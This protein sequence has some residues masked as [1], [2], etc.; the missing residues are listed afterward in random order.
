M[1]SAHIPRA[2][3]A[4]VPRD[5]LM[6]ALRA[7]GPGIRAVTGMD[8]AG[9]TQLAAA[10]GRECV[11]AGWRL[12]A[13]I[14]AGDTQGILDGLAEVAGLLG[15]KKPG[16]DLTVIAEE[17]RNRVE[18]DGHRCLVVFDNVTDPDAV[19][20]YLPAAGKA[21]V[22]VTSTVTS[23]ES[24]GEPLRVEVFTQPQSLRLLA[25]RT[26]ADDQAGA[27]ALSQELGFLPLA[28]AQAAPVIAAQHL[29]YPAYLERL[30]SY[31]PRRPAGGEPYPRGVAEAIELSIDAVT[32]AGPAGLCADLLDTI[33]LL[34]QDGVSRQL[35]HAA[36]AAG[37]LAGDAEAVDEALGALAD[38]SLIVFSGDGSTL[39]A[40]SLVMRVAAERRI[41]DGTLLAV[42]ARTCRVLGAFRW[43]LGL[44]D[45]WRHPRAVREFVRHVP[46]LNDRLGPYVPENAELTADLLNLRG[47]ALLSLVALGDSA[48]QAIDLGEPLVAERQ[49]V[50]GDAHPDTLMSRNNLAVAY[51]SAGRLGEALRL[52]ERVR[53]DSARVLGEADPETLR[54]GSNL[55]AAYKKAGR[56][57]EAV[58]LL[59][60][61]VADSVRVLG[62]THPDA[63]KSRGNL[64]VAYGEAGRQEE[65]AAL[66][67]GVVA[68]SA[69]VLGD[70]HPDTLKHLRNLAIA[71]LESGRLDEA[72]VE[73]EWVLTL[74][75]DALGAEHPDTLESRRTLGQAYQMAGRGEEAT[76]LFERALA[77]SERALGDGH[78]DTVARADRSDA[79]LRHWAKRWHRRRS[80]LR[81]SDERTGG[82]LHR[83][84]RGHLFRVRAGGCRV[85]DRPVCP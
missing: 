8:G 78:P 1:I 26:S 79:S 70:V 29:T 17:V 12:V 54:A 50:L 15:V 32:A 2:A 21:Q 6:A 81:W 39:T 75:A 3:A 7:A 57:R 59:E 64:A 80:R 83:R 28:L 31:S 82:S 42:G 58:A 69:R 38:A 62:E 20:P 27:R 63:L 47:S 19:R 68:G 11:D 40:H 76:A 55:A 22:V 74:R 85:G 72:V 30:R 18:A 4:F 41:R 36:A 10:Y 53:A 34:S 52:L 66:L 65:A 37:I 67:P 49:R 51:Q 9:K 77:G 84:V 56:L 43:S 25:E 16:T 23:A 45:E 61:V 35:L 46:A 48:R 5:D 24:L 14:N 13:W 73:L 60:A 71:D 33:C 44:G